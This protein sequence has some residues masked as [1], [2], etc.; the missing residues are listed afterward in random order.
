MT[1]ERLTKTA[2]KFQGMMRY[3]ARIAVEDELKKLGLYRDKKDNKMVLP[4]CSRSGGYH[5]TTVEAPVV[6]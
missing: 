6:G 1:T 3:D 5:R 4:I 2:G